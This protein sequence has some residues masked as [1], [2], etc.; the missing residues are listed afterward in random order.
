MFGGSVPV[1]LDD[2]GSVFIDRDGRQFKKI[3][4]YLRNG[5]YSSFFKI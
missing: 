1:K 5:W 4:S 2:Q 3:L